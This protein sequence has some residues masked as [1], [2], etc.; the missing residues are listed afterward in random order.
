MTAETVRSRFVK[1][2]HGEMPSDRLPV[3]E[4]AT[5]WHL[6]IQRW[7]GEGLPEH[8]DKEGIKRYFGLDVDYQLW[9]GQMRSDTPPS[10]YADHWIESERDYDALRP[11][12]YPDPVPFD[13]DL[14]RRRA[15]EQQA[16]EA[17]IWITFSGFFWWPRVLLGIEPHLYAF[18]DQP[19]LMHR[20][21]QDQADYLNRCLEAFCEV[22]TPDFMTFGE[23]MSYNHGPMLS[24][25]LFYAF[26]A[27]YYRQIVPKLRE[28]G[29]V[30]MVDSDGDVEPLIPWLESVGLEGILPLERMAGVDVARLR[31][32][33]PQWR[34]I[35][36]FDKTVMHC[37]EG[38][39]RRE[40][41]RLLPVMRSGGFIPSVDHQTPPAVSMED[42]RLYLRLL[43]EY[44]AKAAL[45]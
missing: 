4:W 25:S 11:Y 26:L 7:H 20:I 39:M 27:P 34:M 8:L 24:R 3:I 12:L 29:I 38:A 23:D 21:N 30:A 36:G 45:N 13:R 22:C 41:E 17:V 9:F 43:R 15:Q 28:R 42:Y 2:L 6:T 33:H 31:D 1:A 10:R 19:D 14:W 35:G 32:R 5:W 37:G 44:A 18:Y 16:G 40:F